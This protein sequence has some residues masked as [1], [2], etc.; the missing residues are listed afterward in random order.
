MYNAQITPEEYVMRGNSAV[1]KCL[2]PSFVADFVYVDAWI[3]EDGNEILG[4]GDFDGGKEL[5]EFISPNIL[6]EI[7]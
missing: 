3:N 1:L 2:I 7:L 4:G 6:N 5:I